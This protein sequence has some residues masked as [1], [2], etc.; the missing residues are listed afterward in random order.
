MQKT[1]INLFLITCL[2]TS[3]LAIQPNNTEAAGIG[4]GGK[5]SSLGVGGELVGGVMDNLNLRAG[6]QGITYDYD[7]TY[8]GIYYEAELELFSTMLLLDFFPLS[9]NFRISG[10]M[11]LN[12]N[13]LI[14]TGTAEDG[15]YNIGGV[16]YPSSLVGSV[17]GTMDFN[18][19]SPY[20]GFG[21][22][23]LLTESGDWHFFMDIGI[24]YQGSPNLSYTATGP[25]ASNPTF[26]ADLEREKQELE[27]DIDEFEY[28]PVISMGIMY[29]F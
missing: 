19:V 16:T 1:S 6:I 5:V 26:Q 9:N 29:Q 10:G 3:L 12:K 2:I 23:G 22:G 21:Y 27:E 8:S 20:V 14:V 24:L 28:Y 18:T 25:L 7:D 15:T 4:A 17:T 11:M 13:E